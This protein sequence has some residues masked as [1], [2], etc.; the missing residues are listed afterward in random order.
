MPLSDSSRARRRSPQPRRVATLHITDYR[1]IQYLANQ[2]MLDITGHP[3]LP[4]SIDL[5]DQSGVSQ[6]RRLSGI[7]FLDQ[8]GIE[9]EWAVS[10]VQQ[11]V[12]GSLGSASMSI[13]SGPSPRTMKAFEEAHILSD[14]FGRLP[15]RSPSKDITAGSLSSG[16]TP[17]SH[18]GTPA[19]VPP[20]R[21]VRPPRVRPT[22]MD[23][24]EPFISP[25]PSEWSPPGSIFGDGSPEAVSIPWRLWPQRAPLR[26]ITAEHVPHDMDSDAVFT[27]VESSSS[28]SAVST[29][30]RRPGPT[31]SKRVSPPRRAASKRKTRKSDGWISRSYPVSAPRVC[32]PLRRSPRRS[33]SRAS[34]ASTTPR[35]VDHDAES[36]S[37]RSVSHIEVW[38]SPSARV[39]DHG[40]DN[41]GQMSPFGR[42]S[43]R[44]PE[45]T[46]SLGSV[47]MSL[48]SGSW[49]SQTFIPSP[50]VSAALP[51]RNRYQDTVSG[52]SSSIAS[53]T[54]QASRSAQSTSP[55]CPLSYFP[56]S[57]MTS[58]IERMQEMS[59]VGSTGPTARPYSVTVAEH[60]THAEAC[61][62]QL[63]RELETAAEI[64]FVYLGCSG[65]GK[66][67]VCRSRAG[68]RCEQLKGS[69][70]ERRPRKTFRWLV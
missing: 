28:A 20:P 46:A 64:D 2:L 52:P 56:T 14:P 40:H 30:T 53:P 16:L 70:E 1:G 59:L 51:T 55:V 9:Q 5:Y 27:N 45:E 68:V 7:P 29:P 31:G 38:V 23:F 8:E 44:A 47:S 49:P 19:A 22:A 4:F 12:V 61:G 24:I 26:D 25:T 62:E 54:L 48:S 15:G 18:L 39:R 42:S 69:E 58:P 66:M 13:S 33:D 43:P 3:P 65:N 11:E 63:S 10:D 67:V 6:Y 17:P 32:K 35:T 34:G 50:T 37:A 36:E 57:P 41:P 60:Q 21:R